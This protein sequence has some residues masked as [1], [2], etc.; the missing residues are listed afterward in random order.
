MRIL[1]LP[2][3]PTVQHIQFSNRRVINK[4]QHFFTVSG[5]ILSKLSFKYLVVAIIDDNGSANH[6]KELRG[7][8]PYVF[9]SS[10]SCT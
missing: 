5:F 2:N 7:H 9:N 6:E 3:L 4:F 8:S 10:S 1:F